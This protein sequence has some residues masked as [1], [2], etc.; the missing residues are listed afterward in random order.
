MLPELKPEYQLSVESEKQAEQTFEQTVE[1][2]SDEQ[3]STSQVEM[4]LSIS[5]PDVKEWVARR[6]ENIRHFGTFFN[7]NNFQVK[8]F[9]FI[10]FSTF[11]FSDSALCWP[12]D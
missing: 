3:T 6:K 8:S 9:H 5:Q 12:P 1:Q 11:S 2:T 4:S 7:T 10:L